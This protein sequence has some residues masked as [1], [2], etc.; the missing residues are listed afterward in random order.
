M[1]GDIVVVL[2]GVAFLVFGRQF[3]QINLRP[4]V[5][6]QQLAER[7]KPGH[8]RLRMAFTWIWAANIAVGLIFIY[9]GVQ[10]MR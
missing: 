6:R 2:V 9:A 3:A 7:G 4:F 8:R 10:A 5:S 1:L